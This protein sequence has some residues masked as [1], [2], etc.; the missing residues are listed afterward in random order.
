MQNIEF[1]FSNIENILA[2]FQYTFFSSL[3]L[4]FKSVEGYER[5]VHFTRYNFEGK[6]H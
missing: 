1:I 5:A 3:R 4:I 6:N 2:D